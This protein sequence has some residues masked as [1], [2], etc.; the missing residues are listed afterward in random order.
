MNF[1]PRLY[2][3]A[4]FVIF[5]Q[6]LVA[7]KESNIWYFG[8]NAGLDFNSGTPVV[9]TDGK[10][11]TREGVASI[12]DRSTG[13]LLFYTEGTQVWDAGHALMPNGTGLLGDYSSTQSS[14]VIP[15]PAN[16]NLYYL[17][18]TA[19]DRGVRYSKIDMRLNGGKGDVITASKNTS[20]LANSVST[21]KIIAVQ[22]CNKRDY[23]VIT[24]TIPNNTFY[25]YLITAA[26]VQAP[27]TYNIGSPIPTSN[28]WTA[29]G[30]LKLSPA[31]NK[32]AHAI[33]PETQGGNSVV[34]LLN[35]NNINGVIS[36]P[37]TQLSG[38]NFAYGVEFSPDQNLLY[39]SEVEG[40]K[41]HQFNLNA[42]NV[43]A[44]KVT[45]SSSPNLKYG[46]LQL[47]PT[48]KIYV[49]MENGYDVSYNFLGVID[50][51]NTLGTGCSF[52]PNAID[53]KGGK[54]LIGLPTFLAN[55][56]KDTSAFSVT[57]TCVQKA[58]DFRLTYTGNVDSVR[59]T[60]GDGL[61][62]KGGVAT[63][64]VYNRAGSYRVSA[65]IFRA[66]SQNDT[67][68]R[69]VDVVSPGART[70]SATICSGERFTLPNGT[71]V[72]EAGEYPVSYPTVTGCDSIVTTQLS[73]SA[74]PQVNL[75]RDTAICAGNILTLN[76]G[77][78]YAAYQ[79]S[80]SSSGAVLG[81]ATPGTYW[82]EVR[83]ASGCRNRD[84]IVITALS[85]P[86]FSLGNDN[87]IC[88]E[89]SY[90]IAPD[91]VFRSY[92]WQDGS[93]SAQYQA[94]NPGL[95]WL[96]V[97]TE[98]GCRSRDS[99]NI[100]IASTAAIGLGPDTAYCRGS[101]ITIGKALADAKCE[102]SNGST[103]SSITVSN[104]G[105]Y[106]VAVNQAGCINR[107]S[108]NITQ[109]EKSNDIDCTIP[110]SRLTALGASQFS[111]SPGIG[112]NDSTSNNPTV[113]ISATRDYILK[114][115]DGFGCSAYDTVSVKVTSAGARQY[116]LPNAFTPNGDGRN[117]CFGLST[118]GAV[119]Q[120]NLKIYNRWGG[121]VFSGNS[122]KD[123]WDGTL[124]G[125]PQDSGGFVYIVQARTLCGDVK[126]KGIVM[127][128]R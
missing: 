37:V 59:W 94:R 127:L 89:A 96:E 52:E 110:S 55:Y 113:R 25:V 65:I 92:L 123:C 104:P 12:S 50:K 80:N 14:I 28:A 88:S 97:Q 121:V 22:H 103:S 40:K 19:L 32:I 61:L 70:V 53:L 10:I 112:L 86:R 23:W 17:F 13:K 74:L 69:R 46:A 8:I 1:R 109:R 75:G 24:H 29:V 125:K 42:A 87:T 43:N 16:S 115:T 51:P 95:Y 114:G 56:L 33:G 44:S 34:E 2:L 100:K 124:N 105:I 20:L 6:V 122:I 47:G 7:Q 3:T 71:V 78:G 90:R 72:T 118:W 98:N 26:G 18:T 54:T 67:V 58:V 41:L 84:S 62:T 128:I 5:V 30:Y 39:V 64:H 116:Q 57:G 108:I 36:G 81:T 68:I 31:G 49:S 83:N 77:S 27:L 66:C 101:A 126:Q 48:G 106:W 60:F 73:V 91:N 9:L 15:D 79:W 38:F 11:A 82:V 76:A 21:E 35:F 107:D 99:V 45:L 85:A 120:V 111:W 93:T 117:D 63:Q 4:A 102:W 119:E